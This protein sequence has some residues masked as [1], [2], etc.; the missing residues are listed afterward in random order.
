MSENKDRDAPAAGVS[1]TETAADV[2][3]LVLDIDGTIVDESNRVRDSVARAVRSAQRR[4]VAVAIATGRLYQTSLRAYDSIG[5][6]SPLIC[7]EGALIREPKSGIVHHHRPLE[8]RVLARVLE[9]ADLLSLSG[10]ASVHFH[11]QDEVYVSNMNDAS[12]DYFA[13]SK[14]EP[15]V[16]SDLR[17]LLNRPTTKVTV[18][19]DD[20]H[21]I[22]RLSNELK[23]SGS[24]THVKQ[25]GS[26]TLL[27][28]FHPAA[29]K[30]SAVSHL[31]ERIMGLSPEN[32]MAIGNDFS[33][34]EMLRYAG[35][36]VAMGDA[37]AAVR[38]SA[39]W[40]TAT[41][42]KDGVARAIERWILRVE[43]GSAHAP[44]YRGAPAA[45]A[46]RSYNSRRPSVDTRTD[47]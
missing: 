20:A 26:T 10:R 16:V 40:V 38:A 12:V 28:A 6:T 45:K 47:S 37:P 33:D 13:R 2:R 21:V 41:I 9:R 32:V 1:P 4:G 18:L 44:A 29:N 19:S 8:R 24:R 7:Y 35:I 34:V 43:S 27:E 11:V 25:D 5:S 15:V 46:S 23:N 17:R 22:T 39:D 3:L 30:R 42:E 14:V 31:A 36:G